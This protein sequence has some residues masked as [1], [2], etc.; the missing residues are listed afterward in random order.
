MASKM[1]TPKQQKL[2]KLVLENMGM[3]KSSKSL[4]ELLLEAGY[5][6]T[7]AKNPYL[8]FKSEV[9]KDGLADFIGMLDDKRRMAVTHITEKKLAKAPAR[10]LAYVADVLTKNHQLLTGG[11]TENLAQKVLVEFIDA[12]ENTDTKGV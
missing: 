3:T 2:I 9:I 5:S 6:K 11:S 8:I 4:G 7:I 1:P 12:K 10:E